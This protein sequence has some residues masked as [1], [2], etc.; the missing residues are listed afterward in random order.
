VLCCGAAQMVRAMRTLGAEAG[1]GTQLTS[2][3]A[4]SLESLAAVL[5]AM[6][7]TEPKR[8]PSIS[9]HLSEAVRLLAWAFGIHPRPGI[10]KGTCGHK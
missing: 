5:S 6:R 4:P 1:H 3:P 9:V 7:L 2:T 10:E 8:S